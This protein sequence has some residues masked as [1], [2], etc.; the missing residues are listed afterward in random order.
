MFNKTQSIS[1]N[2][3]Y[4]TIEKPLIPVD[5]FGLAVRQKNKYLISER[6]NKYRNSSSPFYENFEKYT[7]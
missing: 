2:N 3:N 5:E 7:Q 6:K 4:Q 1:L